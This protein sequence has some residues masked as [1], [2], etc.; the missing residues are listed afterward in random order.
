MLKQEKVTNFTM[1]SFIVNKAIRVDVTYRTVDEALER[2]IPLD[3]LDIIIGYYSISRKKLLM[4]TFI[5]LT[6]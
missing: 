1:N 6:S 2:T 4:L 5:I 3:I